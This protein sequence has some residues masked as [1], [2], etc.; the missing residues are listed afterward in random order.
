MPRTPYAFLAAIQVLSGVFSVIFGFISPAGFLRTIDLIFGV[1]LVV[2]AVLTWTLAPRLRNGLGLGLSLGFTETLAVSGIF[3]VNDAEGQLTVGLALV[4]FGVF[5]GY[6][7]QK[8]M[9]YAHVGLLSI[10]W[11][12]GTVVNDHLS[13]PVSILLVALVIVGV[14][15]MV[16][17]L[18]DHLRRQALV[19]P[20]TE[21]LNRRGLDLVVPQVTATAARGDRPVTVALLD[22]DDFKGFNDAQ[23]HLAGDHALVEVADAWTA[24][25]RGSDV[26]A[27]FGGDEFALVLPGSTPQQAQELV[28]RVRRRTGI[29][30]SIGFA[31]WIPGEDVYLALNRAD[32]ALFDAKRT[33]SHDPGPPVL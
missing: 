2:M 9:L 15:L 22:L 24:E 21:V 18:A 7:R 11:V 27:R 5:A 12:V 10:G 13:T 23:G 19:D 31:T 32:A 29:G 8:P 4:M 6:F 25:L 17:S 33:R 30:F 20:L 14:S 3:F 26:I 28:A 16:A 1:V